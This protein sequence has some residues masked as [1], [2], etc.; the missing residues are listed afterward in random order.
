MCLRLRSQTVTPI[1]PDE[2]KLIFDGDTI[3]LHPSI[4]NWKFPCESHYLICNDQVA[5]G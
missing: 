5:I 4:G 3:T 2:Y 1:A